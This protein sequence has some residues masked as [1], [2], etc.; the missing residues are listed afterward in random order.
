MSPVGGNC[1]IYT[2][3]DVT[4]TSELSVRFYDQSP[5]ERTV[6]GQDSCRRHWVTVVLHARTVEQDRQPPLF[7]KTVS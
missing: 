3:V 1:R 7:V 5:E 6:F 2:L 4:A